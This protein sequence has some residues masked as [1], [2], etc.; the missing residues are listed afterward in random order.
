MRFNPCQPCCIRSG[1]FFTYFNNLSTGSGTVTNTGSL[2]VY[3]NTDGYDP[4]NPGQTMS[5]TEI[6]AISCIRPCLSLCGPSFP[7]PGYTTTP[8]TLHATLSCP[9]LTAVLTKQMGASRWDD[10][11]SF[12]SGTSAVG[13]GGYYMVVN[14]EIGCAVLYDVSIYNIANPSS[15]YWGGSSEGGGCTNGTVVCNPIDYVV[16]PAF[17]IGFPPY[18]TPLPACFGSPTPNTVFCSILEITE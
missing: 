8:D 10:P 5:G 12:Y 14:L 13:L 16:E 9:A 3:I 4:V 18:T 2:P 6:G 17:I 15:P 11:G 7:V 1:C